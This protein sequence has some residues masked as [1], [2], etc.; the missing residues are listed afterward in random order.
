MSAK[1]GEDQILLDVE[2]RIERGERKERWWESDPV[3][4]HHPRGRTTAE[5]VIGRGGRFDLRNRGR[6]GGGAG[7]GVAAAG[8][9]FAVL[10]AWSR[11]ALTRV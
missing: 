1:S 9:F 8:A 7:A 11:A 5:L 6:V 2:F 10:F 3:H 4:P